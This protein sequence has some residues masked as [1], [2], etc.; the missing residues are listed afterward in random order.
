[1]SARSYLVTGGTGFLGSALVR[2]LVRDGYRVRVLDN[3]SRGFASR[4]ADVVGMFEMI[5]GDVRDGEA[6]LR[7]ARGMDGI[8]HLAFVNGTGSFYTKPDLV[9][10]VGVRGMLSVIDAGARLCISD[11]IL[12]SS[13]EVYQTPPE[14]PT[15][16]CVSLAIPEVLN[17]RY[18]YAGGKLISELMSL[19]WASKYFARVAIFRPHNVY[20]PDMG[21]DHVIPQ[22]ALRMAELCEANPIG[23]IAFPI[24]GTGRETRAFVHIDDMIEG[25]MC[26]IERGRHLNVYHVGTDQEISIATLAGEVARCFDRQ[27]E[28]VAGPLKPGGTPRRCPDISKLRVLGYEP[29]VSLSY[30][31]QQTVRWYRDDAAR[32]REAQ[33]R[34]A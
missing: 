14:V 22:F 11:L 27:I 13:S 5:E 21:T 17:P 20:G 8:V 10:D 34:V 18:S 1:V 7:A 19:H 4:L 3:N 32:N 26:V 2:R 9:L 24:E 28:L 29:C 16:E 30:G 6:V 25:A 12:A 23:R 15:D 33:R 31:L